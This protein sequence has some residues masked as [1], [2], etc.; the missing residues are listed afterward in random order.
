VITSGGAKDAANTQAGAANE[1][2]KASTAAANQA[3]ALQYKMYQQGQ[4]N[5]APWLQTGQTALAA[6]QSGMGLGGNYMPSNAG[7]QVNSPSNLG[8]QIAAPSGV[9]Q[10]VLGGTTADTGGA[11]GVA[12]A[13]PSSDYTAAGLTNY[14]ATPE[15]MQQAADQYAGVDGAGQFTQTFAPSDLN[16]DPSYKFRLEQGTANMNASA[17]ARGTLGSGQNL[18][19]ITNYGQ[20]AAS[21]EYQ[22]AYDRF[23]NNQNTAYNRLAGLAGT[24][25]NAGTS[26]TSSGTSAAGAMGQNTM[27]GMT[28][29]TNALMG[30]ANAQAAGTM[31]QANALSSGINSGISNW[32]TNK[33]MSGGYNAGGAAAGASMNTPNAVQYSP[34][35][36]SS[37]ATLLA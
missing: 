22:A 33:Y 12:G 30:G 4:Q 31:G 7:P 27:A 8:T 34:A 26:M 5:Q 37:M 2:S 17:A 20:S 10:S 13:A 35:E 28:A 11:V 14:G 36:T 18:K 6:L 25:Q 15:A 16:L 1:A 9:A 23:M 24:G 3:N 29:S 32:M 19:D 21:Q